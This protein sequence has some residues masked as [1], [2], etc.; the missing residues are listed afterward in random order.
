MNDASILLRDMAGDAATKAASKVRPSDDQLSQMDNPADNNVWHDS[1]NMSMGNIRNQLKSAVGKNAPVNQGDIQ[2]AVGNAS[3]SAHPNG[4]RDPADT[5]ALA[6]QDQQNNTSSGVNAQSGAQ[7]GVD[8]L[9]Q[10]ASG[11]IPEER[12]EQARKV[13]ERTKNYL[14]SKMPEERRDQAI[15]RLKKMI[16]EIQGHS[17]CKFVA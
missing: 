11:N 16:I 13:R 10:R 12:K 15:W 14:N 5:A 1:P 3:Q 8:T 4:S 2:D 7:A 6:S 17:D 9:R